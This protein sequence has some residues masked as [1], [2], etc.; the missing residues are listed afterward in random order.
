MREPHQGH[1]LDSR[2]RE[3][4]G[5]DSFRYAKSCHS[6]EAPDKVRVGRVQNA[7][8]ALDSGLHL[9]D[10]RKKFPT[11]DEIINDDVFRGGSNLINGVRSTGFCGARMSRHVKMRSKS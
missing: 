5:V 3:N 4:D 7:L 11:F 10:G 2:I 9:I 8:K 6:G 1:V